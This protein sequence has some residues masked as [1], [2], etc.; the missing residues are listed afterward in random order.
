MEITVLFE[1]SNTFDV[2]YF[3]EYEYDSLMESPKVTRNST[4]FAGDSVSYKINA[5]L[6]STFLLLFE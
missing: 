1:D 2:V 4:A 5:A 3:H 6:D